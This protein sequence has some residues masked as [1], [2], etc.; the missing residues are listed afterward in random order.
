VG[1]EQ[2]VEW[3]VRKAGVRKVGV[4]EPAKDPVVEGLAWVDNNEL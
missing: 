1:V 3:G 4:G 2:G